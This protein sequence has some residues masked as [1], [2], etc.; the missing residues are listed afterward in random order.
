MSSVVDY[1]SE[2]GTLAS[3]G[4][5]PETYAALAQSVFAEW[6]QSTDVTRALDVAEAVWRAVNDLA[7]LVR[8]A[9]GADTVALTWP[10]QGQLFH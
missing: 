9:V 10:A 2:P 7:C 4:A 5:I 8:I 1:L 6:Q 3:Q